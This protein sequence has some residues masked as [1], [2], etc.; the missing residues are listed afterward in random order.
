M[1]EKICLS[2]C[3]ISRTFSTAP[4]FHPRMKQ[5]KTIQHPN[6]WLFGSDSGGENCTT[7]VRWFCRWGGN[8][9]P[10]DFALLRCLV[11]F[12]AF[13]GSKAE[14]APWS[15]WRFLRRLILALSAWKEFQTHIWKVKDYTTV[16]HCFLWSH[17]NK[18][19]GGSSE[20]FTR[21]T[22]LK[23]PE[24]GRCD[25]SGKQT[26]ECFVP[27]W[28]LFALN[29]RHDRTRSMSKL[30]TPSRSTLSH[31]NILSRRVR[32]RRTSLLWRPVS[33]LVSGPVLIRSAPL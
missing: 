4:G 2:L 16:S 26:P 9:V 23:P 27:D 13:R 32:S 17:G 28:K 22:E 14:S 10:Y 3:K 6:I 8:I 33:P 18:Q 12:P 1:K 31:S 15:Q 29:G 7:G 24:M 30:L 11:P 25:F 19:P 5:D 20:T 21:H